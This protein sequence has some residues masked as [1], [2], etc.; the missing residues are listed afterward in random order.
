MNENKETL[1]FDHPSLR[2]ILDGRKLTHRPIGE[3]NPLPPRKKLRTTGKSIIK[4]RS[5][6]S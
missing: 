3:I 1:S 5:Q 2:S 6:A 4:Y